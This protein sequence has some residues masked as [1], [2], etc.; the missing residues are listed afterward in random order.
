MSG[1][2]WQEWFENAWAVREEKIHRSLF[3]DIGS[4]IYPLDSELFT[5]QFRQTSI[6]PA[7]PCIPV[8]EERFC[9]TAT[10]ATRR[11]RNRRYPPKKPQTGAP[12]NIRSCTQ[13]AWESLPEAIE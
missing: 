2:T 10:A 5:G 12:I 11:C 6:D 3:G 1:Q 8:V 13:C 9:Y 4:E 7:G